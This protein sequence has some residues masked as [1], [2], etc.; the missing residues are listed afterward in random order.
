[1]AKIPKEKLRPL[2]SL[3]IITI[4]GLATVSVNKI[5]LFVGLGLL[6]GG[7][8]HTIRKHNANGEAHLYALMIAGAE[9]YFR[10]SSV[11]L[12]WEFGKYAAII[13][14]LTGLIIEKR[15]QPWPVI[16]LLY[17][18]LFLPSIFILDFGDFDVARKSILFNL[19]GQMVLF[20]SV[21]YFYGRKINE[22]DFIKLSRWIIYGVFIMSVYIFIKVPD[23]AAIQYTANSITDA[24]GGFSGNQVSTVF[25]LGMVVLGINLLRKVTLFSYR[26]VDIALFLL[27]TFQGMITMSRGGIISA[28]LSITFGII[29]FQLTS[30]KQVKRFFSVNP[31]KLIFI[32]IVLIIGF[33]ITNYI[34]QGVLTQ[35][36]FNVDEMGQS[37]EKDYTTGRGAIATA[38]F[39]IFMENPVTGVGP[40]QAMSERY[41][42]TGRDEAAHIEFSRL[43]S[44]HGILGMI[45]LIIILI[46]PIVRYFKLKDGFSRFFLTVF[47]LYALLTMSHAAL[48]LA[49]PGLMYGLAFITIQREVYD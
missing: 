44:E 48:R 21:L 7:L 26:I 15:K 38:D 27:F 13:L 46:F 45:A 5:A 10:M 2:G 32:G 3:L 41:L 24:S 25:G 23:Y 22:T 4:I 35:R 40:G 29:I 6:I 34:T 47:V 18:V 20:V 33:F 17:P 12:P 43:L 37:R 30:G 39:S 1:M 31:V 11:G 36:Y 28:L 9:V 16:F 42:Y 8:I 19:S 14:L 49:I